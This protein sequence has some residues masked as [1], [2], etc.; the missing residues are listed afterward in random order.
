MTIL[1]TGA[2]GH[3]GRLTIDALLARGADAGE[4]IAAGRSAE[5]L[6]A[7]A[8][9]GIR[10]RQLDFAD[11]ASLDLAGIDT[12]LL[13]S[14][15]EPGDRARL[16]A[17][18]IDAA[19][20][21]GVAKLVYTSAPH[22]DSADYSLAPDHRATEAYLAE[23][24]VPA[25][26]ARNNWYTEL[27]AAEVRTA[28]ETG[29]IAASVGDGRVASAPPADYAEGLAVLLLDDGHLGRTYEFTGD[30]AWGFD[31]L[32]AAASELT[33]RTVVYRAQT[34]EER[35]ADLAAAGLDAGTVDFVLSVDDTV[36]RGVLADAEP[37]LADLIGRPTTPLLEA[38]RAAL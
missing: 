9:R 36:R 12:V 3:L 1:V 34:P 5:K 11:P 30:T 17:N 33:G 29:V 19:K 13:V 10:A 18:V 2:T 35:A 37:T 22:V 23:S 7:Y 8:E 14:G 27:Y 24:G 21:A 16:H 25:V 31:E 32:A 38:L 20:A 6:A 26:V 4:L 15:S 28:A